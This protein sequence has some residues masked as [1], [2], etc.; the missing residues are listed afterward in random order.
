M[1]E[2]ISKQERNKL[3]DALQYAVDNGITQY[4]G[5]WVQPLKH[6]IYDLPPK[7]GWA[8]LQHLR[9][10]EIPTCMCVQTAIA[11]SFDP[12]RIN[13]LIYQGCEKVDGSHFPNGFRF[14]V[15][16]TIQQNIGVSLRQVG[17]GV[18]SQFPDI[19]TWL[20]SRNDSVDENGLTFE[21]FIKVLR[22]DEAWV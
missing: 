20:E 9:V 8:N 13:N 19:R 1:L 18:R 17:C 4:R 16:E 2:P 3:A 22:N 10:D 14:V 5:S 21:Q 12:E 15:E 6:K 7:R 11:W